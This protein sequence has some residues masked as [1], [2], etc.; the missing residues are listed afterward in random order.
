MGYIAILISAL[1]AAAT[2][3]VLKYSLDVIDPIILLALRFF[4]AFIILHIFTSVNKKS[5]LIINKSLIL[6]I[7]TAFSLP[8]AVFFVIESLKYITVSTANSV[9]LFS[10]AITMLFASYFLKEKVVHFQRIGMLISTLGVII[11][12]ATSSHTDDYAGYLLII[13]AVIM[14]SIYTIISRHFS[15]SYS[16]LDIAYISFFDGFVLYTIIVLMQK[17]KVLFTSEII[18]LLLFLV[19]IG[20]IGQFVLYQYG[21]KSTSAFYGSFPVYSTTINNGIWLYFFA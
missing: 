17:T 21:V 6:L 3:P 11:L 14:T 8:L 9:L 18:Y 13:C 4:A 15:K 2:L 20:T 16:P 5:C 7:I 10:P 19:I 1:F 12:V